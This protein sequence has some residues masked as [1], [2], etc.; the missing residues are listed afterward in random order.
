M[1]K[2]LKQ[3]FCRHKN[4]GYYEKKSPFRALNGVRVFRICKGCG[5]I[6]DSEVLDT[7][8]FYRRFKF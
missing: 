3:L 7:E 4:V 2:F 1:K 5:K 6:I 8:E